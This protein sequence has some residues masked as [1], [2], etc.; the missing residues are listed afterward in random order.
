MTIETGVHRGDAQQPV[1]EPAPLL[2]IVATS[3][4]DEFIPMWLP[5]LPDL[6]TIEVTPTDVQGSWVFAAHPV[7]QHFTIRLS[8]EDD[9]SRTASPT[10][11]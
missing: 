11:T 9:L 6:P 4:L 3:G 10:R 7:A 2:P 5:R 1:E 8:K